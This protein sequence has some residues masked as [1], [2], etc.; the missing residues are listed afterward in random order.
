MPDV[1]H[2]QVKSMKKVLSTVIIC[3]IAVS[4][5]AQPKA[6]FTT[7]KFDNFTLHTYASFDA[8]ADVSF[9]VEGEKSL[10]IIEPQAFEGHVEEFKA[11]VLP[12]LCS[13]KRIPRIQKPD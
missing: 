5:S 4:A 7:D 12:A 2:K 8:M 9:I 3:T 13:C 1:G 6:N 11:G 10:V